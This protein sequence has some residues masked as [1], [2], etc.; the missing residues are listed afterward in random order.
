MHSKQISLDW[1]L[2]LA[3]AIALTV[4]VGQS[5]Q[6]QTYKVLYSFTGGHDGASPE[7]GL[8]IDRGGNLY[9]TTNGGGVGYGAVFKL[10]RKN[11][12]W[13]FNTLYSFAGGIDGAGT[14][15]R[16]V[17]GPDGSLY[18]ATFGSDGGFGTVFK[19]QPPLTACKSALCPW[20]ETVLYRF[21]GSRDGANP[22]GDLA[23]DQAGNLYGVTLGGGYG[24]GVVYEL[25]L[26]N[27]G[28]TQSLLHLFERGEDGVFPAAGL[29][30]DSSGNLY[31]TTAY[32][33][34]HGLGVLFQLT[35]SG[36]GWIENLLYAFQGGTDGGVPVAGLIADESGSFYGATTQNGTGSGGTAFELTPS[37]GN[38]SFTLLYSFAGSAGCG[39]QASL[40]LDHAGSLYGTTLCDGANRQGSVFKLTPSKGTWT[41]TSLHDFAGTDGAFPVSNLVFDENGN[42]YGTAS[43]GGANGYG[44]VFEITP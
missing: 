6:A 30:F 1:S 4:S 14:Y 3:L 44:V 31:G 40:A 29:I 21:T 10:A 43:E 24:F 26:S 35:P 39:P 28:W 17:F 33:S 12:N 18:G 9:G 36:S 38:W 16:V 25:T 2:T 42:L 34:A 11:S 32:G 7:A 13:I 5:A 19:L 23:F 22:E 27:G 37:N 41:Y 15:S 20:A 8:T